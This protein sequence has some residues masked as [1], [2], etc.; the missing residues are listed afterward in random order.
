MIFKDEGYEIEVISK[1]PE[2]KILTSA[3]Y[4]FCER[5]DGWEWKRE[6]AKDWLR[7]KTT[8]SEFEKN[9]DA[10]LGKLIFDKSN[11]FP[12]L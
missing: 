6:N 10:D 8:Y 3:V 9:L 7:M 4:Y 2:G 11:H 1:S 12:N 5:S